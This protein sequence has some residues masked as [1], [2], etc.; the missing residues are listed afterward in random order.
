MEKRETSSAPVESLDLRGV[1]CPEN[2]LRALYALELMDEGEVLELWLDES[3]SS[4]RLLES[5]EL[6]EHGIEER[7][8]NSS[9]KR[10]WIHRGED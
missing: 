7:E 6:E 10:V 8:R 2:A 5:L 1:E 3:D 9:S 4:R